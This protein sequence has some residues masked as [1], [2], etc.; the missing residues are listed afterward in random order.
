MSGQ[1]QYHVVEVKPAFLGNITERLQETLDK[2]GR[3]GWEL[4]KV[5]EPA[6]AAGSFLLFFKKEA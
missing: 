4:Q 3:Q 5:V 6:Q 1:W 2:Q